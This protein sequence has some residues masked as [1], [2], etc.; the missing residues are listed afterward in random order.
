MQT[1]P[2]PTGKA[3]KTG[4]GRLVRRLQSAFAMTITRKKNRYSLR[5]LA[6]AELATVS[7][8]II[9]YGSTALG[10]P[11]TSGAVGDGLRDRAII[12]WSGN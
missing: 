3:A 9:I 7:G 5:P 11:D 1:S 4:R 12:F 10:G 6:A 8:G 2:L